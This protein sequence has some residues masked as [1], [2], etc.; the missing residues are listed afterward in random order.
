MCQPYWLLGYTS[1]NLP[2]G[3]KPIG[4]KSKSHLYKVDF[5]F[6]LAQLL[7]QWV[8]HIIYRVYSSHLDMR[9]SHTLLLYVFGLLVRPWTP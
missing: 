1:N 2:L 6:W 5:Q 7:S 4:Q 9:L 3:L 8:C